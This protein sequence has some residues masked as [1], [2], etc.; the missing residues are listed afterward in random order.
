M[1][2]QKSC[3][4]DPVLVINGTAVRRKGVSERC[5]RL[6]H[7]V[8][9]RYPDFVIRGEHQLHTASDIRNTLGPPDLERHAPCSA[10]PQR[11]RS[12]NVRKPSDVIG[13]QVCDE[14]C[15]DVAQR[16][17]R[18]MEPERRS[19]AH[20]EQQHLTARLY[21]SAHAEAIDIKDRRAS[22]EKRDLYVFSPSG[23]SKH[24]AR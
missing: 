6:L 7:H 5:R 11:G 17:L 14:Y 20:V 15:G 8:L 23:A 1:I 3:D 9:L 10:G 13:M 2:H 22:S 18:L 19:S 16:R 12:I 24:Q 21:Q 4:S